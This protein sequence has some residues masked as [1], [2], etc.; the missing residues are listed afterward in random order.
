MKNKYLMLL[1]VIFISLIS[2]NNSIADYMLRNYEDPKDST[3]NI[4]CFKTP[5]TIYLDWEEDECADYFVLR[6]AE[7]TSVIGDHN[8]REI[9]KGT[10][11]QYVDTDLN[12][13]K[14]YVYQ[15]VKYR[16]HT[17]FTGTK[18]AYGVCSPM[19][20]DN[21]E[22]N[23]Y[24]ENATYLNMNCICNTFF[25]PFAN[26]N[27]TDEDWFYVELPGRRT[28]EIIV[29]VE[30]GINS[31]LQWHLETQNPTQI[32]SGKHFFIHNESFDPTRIYFKIEINPANISSFTSVVYTIS[33]ESIIP[34]SN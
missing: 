23:N 12:V 19:I 14:R 29:N 32:V 13:N 10:D 5:Y 3:I 27:T 11:I 17:P 26:N 22:P 28:A 21:Y 31:C 4:E 16:G 34:Y 9:Y 25:A 7:I 15:L 30:D 20:N 33:L 24:K 2:C 8:F 6:R 18:F 1:A